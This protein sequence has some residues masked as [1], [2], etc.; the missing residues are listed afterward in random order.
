MV[1]K[2]LLLFLSPGKFEHRYSFLG[3]KG[4]GNGNGNG[5]GF[6]RIEKLD[7]IIIETM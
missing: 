6:D 7:N 1:V 4:N 5:N 2:L 3:K